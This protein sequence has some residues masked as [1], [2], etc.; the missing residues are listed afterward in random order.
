M[1]IVAA[2]QQPSVLMAA[3]AYARLDLSVVAI[4]GKM[5]SVKW[6]PLQA[7]RSSLYQIEHW[8]RCGLLSSVGVITGAV[9]GN[10]V[11]MDLDSLQTVSKFEFEFPDLLNTYTVASNRGKHIYWYV[12]NLPPTTKTEGYELRANGCYVVAPPS[13]HPSGKSYSVVNPVE[14]ARVHDLDR[15]VEFIEAI[16][17]EKQP[18]PEKRQVTGVEPLP[19]INNR[20]GLAALDDECRKVGATMTEI[21]NQLNLSA[22][23]LGKLVGRGHLSESLVESELLKAASHLSAKDG[24]NLSVK[25]IRSGL[26]AGKASVS[27]RV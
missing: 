16:K 1:S 25:T 20:Y 26:N 4:K 2:S 10:L 8:A 7:R 9:S 15:V 24:E 23:K 11:V 6:I 14:I 3:L 27:G 21:N 5:A 18:E 13:V 19:A 22:F 17:A 12:E